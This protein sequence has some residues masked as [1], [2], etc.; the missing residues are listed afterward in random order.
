MHLQVQNRCINFF[1]KCSHLFFNPS[2]ILFIHT[3][4]ID[5]PIKD[6]PILPLVKLQ[7]TFSVCLNDGNA[8]MPSSNADQTPLPTAVHTHSIYP[9]EFPGKFESLFQDII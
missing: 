9:P 7:K 5:V 1:P 8:F 3:C 2:L 6:H 4:R